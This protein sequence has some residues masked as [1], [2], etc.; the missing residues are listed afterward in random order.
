M[1]DLTTTLRTD[2]LI[3]RSTDCIPGRA[4]AVLSDTRVIGLH[5][6]PMIVWVYVHSN[7]CSG[8]QKTHLFCNRVRVGRSR[9]PGS[10]ILVPIESAMWL[11][12]SPLL[13]LWSC[14]APFLR[15]GD[16]LAKNCLFFLPLSHPAPRSLC[17]LWNFAVTLTARKLESWG[18]SVVKVAGS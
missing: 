4:M 2:Y 18:Y 9:S 5:F 15:Y 3:T 11:P 6:L 13:W 17:F 12:I 16:L 14:R 8:F 1:N 7:F 10:I